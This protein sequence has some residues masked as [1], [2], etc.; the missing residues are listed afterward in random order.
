VGLVRVRG[1]EEGL[2]V[3]VGVAEVVGEGAR[4]RAEDEGVGEE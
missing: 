4:E 2:I 1:E 3:G